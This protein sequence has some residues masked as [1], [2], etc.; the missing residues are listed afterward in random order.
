MDLFV[1]PRKLEELELER[2]GQWV[3]DAPD[4]ET[5]TAE[6]AEGAAESVIAALADGLLE[7]VRQPTLEAAYVAVRSFAALSNDTALR[8]TDA[9]RN[10]LNT[11]ATRGL[12]ELAHEGLEKSN[13]AVVAH[14]STIHA[15]VFF[16]YCI[17]GCVREAVAQE[18]EQRKTEKPSKGRGKKAADAGAAS[19]W[20]APLE[21]LVR[22]LTRLLQAEL[23]GLLYRSPADKARLVEL[24]VLT[25]A[26]CMEDPAAAKQP[27]CAALVALAATR[28]AAGT[29]SLDVA[30]SEL[31]R[32]A[33]TFEPH[34]KDAALAAAKAAIAS[35]NSPNLARALVARF[36]DMAP[37]DWEAVGDLAVVKRA[38]DLLYGIAREL[39]AVMH[40]AISQ[41]MPYFGCQSK[42]TLRGRLVQC[43]GAL[44]AWY[45]GREVDERG[46]PVLQKS[47]LGCVAELLARCN[48][49]GAI[50]REDALG[51]VKELVRGS[52]WPLEQRPAAARRAE[53][54]LTDS[55]SV[56]KQALELLE[57]LAEAC[58][59][60]MRGCPEANLNRMIARGEEKLKTMTPDVQAEGEE[61]EQLRWETE[62]GEAGGGGTQPAAAGQAEGEGE[63]AEAGVVPGTIMPTQMEEAPGPAAGGEADPLSGMTYSQVRMVV[64]TA[65]VNLEV[66]QLLRASLPEVEALLQSESAPVAMQAS[67]LLTLCRLRELAGSEDAQRRV[68]HMVFA[69]EENV[70]GHV[71]HAFYNALQPTDGPAASPA[72]ELRCMEERLLAMVHDLRLCDLQALDELMRLALHRG[73]KSGEP[74]LLGANLTARLLSHLKDAI[75]K[76]VLLCDSGPEES[77]PALLTAQRYAT[78]VGMV[79][80]HAPAQALAGPGRGAAGAGAGLQLLAE[81]LGSS[82]TVLKDPVL[83][84]TLATALGDVAPALPPSAAGA[85]TAALTKLLSVLL[86]AHLPP[87]G[88]PAAARAALG[89]LYQVHP[90]PHTLLEPLLHTLAREALGASAAGQGPGSFGGAAGGSQAGRT[91]HSQGGLAATATMGGAA[92]ATAGGGAAAAPRLGC[93]AEQLSRAVFLVGCV[94]TQQL[95]LVDALAKRVRA[96]RTAAERAAAAAGADDL[97]S[98]LGTSQAKEAQL[99]AWQDELEAE[100]SFGS[101]LVGVWG[102]LISGICRTPDLLGPQYGS[103]GAAALGALTKLM[104]LDV[105]YC[106]ANC[107]VF[108]TRLTASG[109][110][111]LPAPTRC[112]LLVA[113]GDLGRRH[114]NTLEPWTERMFECLQ[115]EDEAVRITCL[116]VLS[117]LIL[118]DMTKPKGHMGHVARCLVARSQPVRELAVCLFNS[119]AKK[120]KGGAN[121]VYQYLPEII[122]SATRPCGPGQQPMAEQDFKEMMQRLLGYIKSDKLADPLKERLCERFANVVCEG[123]Y[124]PPPPL[125]QPEPEPSSAATGA[126]GAAD[127]GAAAAAASAS[128]TQAATLAGPTASAM[129]AQTAATQPAASQAQTQ[130]QAQPAA[131]WTAAGHEA[132]VREWRCLAECLCLLDFSEKG[133]GH[134]IKRLKHYKHALGDEGVYLKFKGLAAHGRKGNR[135]AELKADVGTYEKDLDDAHASLADEQRQRAE[136]AAKAAAAL[137]AAAAE[138]AEAEARA[139]AEQQ[140]QA[141]PAASEAARGGAGAEG[142]EQDG[143]AVEGEEEEEMADAVEEEAEE[144]AEGSAALDPSPQHQQ[145]GVQQGEEEEGEEEEDGDVGPAA[146]EAADASESFRDCREEVSTAGGS[147][148]G[149]GPAAAGADDEEEVAAPPR[150]RRRAAVEARGA[151]EEEEEEA[152][153][154][155]EDEFEDAAEEG[156]G[157]EEEEAEGMDVDEAAEEAGAE[158]DDGAVTPAPGRTRRAHLADGDGGPAPMAEGTPMAITP[159][160]AGGGGGSPSWS[161]SAFNRRRQPALAAAAAAA[162]TPGADGMAWSPAPGAGGRGLAKTPLAAAQPPS[163]LQGENAAGGVGGGAGAGGAFGGFR[164][165]KP[166]PEAAAAAPL[167]PLGPVVGVRI[168][169]DPDALRR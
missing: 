30:A 66:I 1:I 69:K 133:M 53:A 85:L 107:P 67:K 11:V 2:A 106:E 8:L 93:P 14:L 115:D 99:D 108:F 35:F 124:V 60:A 71:L 100:I 103:L 157:Q 45:R 136:A 155:E 150:G 55:V 16:L 129:T 102:Q 137:A 154:E 50:V 126:A 20:A 161:G 117:H 153:G 17:H 32:L 88:W 46:N 39:P 163:R 121:K 104:A 82:H 79:A 144:E 42:A 76:A 10:A 40:V 59:P 97:S 26:R 105:G 75:L 4:L 122:S 9:L 94:A 41:L 28:H 15:C 13:P 68:W 158:A 47:L 123:P 109:A 92:T 5:V 3:A 138:A 64:A 120:S 29:G 51:E 135:S 167:G 80:R 101:S 7:I 114:P 130:A 57:A 143:E 43:L 54:R 25:A 19:F 27:H 156:E 89:A 111:R 164:A 18:A 139:A 140:A 23:D 56:A 83:V 98:Q 113:L 31:F 21:K 62:G 44:V 70:Q 78:L 152:D 131:A 65:K 38:G 86:S 48:D 125:P 12:E 77:R 52:L 74:P 63:G 132:A 112:D 81:C 165:V 127:A 24:C 142:M 72:A 61:Q 110:V 159:A 166:D 162:G 84:R 34:G 141:A 37:E 160:P 49:K 118:S 149:P 145:Q 151:G 148:A 22:A 73:I 146:S 147:A 87:A 119:L 134:I 91:G 96:E 128:A 168:K 169:P 95:V 33:T 90:R 6:D 58:L 116:R 36:C